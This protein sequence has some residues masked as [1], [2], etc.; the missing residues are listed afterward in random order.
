MS[1]WLGNNEN[2]RSYDL[3]M[4]LVYW[5]I[6][7]ICK[8]ASPSTMQSEKLDRKSYLLNSFWKCRELL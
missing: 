6:F 1:Y 7:Y 3:I 5:I 2:H 4:V 8:D